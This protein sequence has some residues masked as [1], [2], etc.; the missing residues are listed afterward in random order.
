MVSSPMSQSSLTQLVDLWTASPL[1]FAN[2]N[3]HPQELRMLSYDLA[4]WTSFLIAATILNLAPGPDIAFILGHT[5][6]GGRASGLAAM[7]GIWS[8]A[9][10]HVAFAAAG[11]SAIVATSALA[12]AAIKWVG[13][14]YLLWLGVQ[15]LRSKGGS[16]ASDTKVPTMGLGPI[17]RQGILIDLLN[18]KVAIFFLAFLPQFVAPGAGPV[19]LQLLV[20]G[21][22]IIAIS[23][24]IEPPIVLL[25]DWLTRKL[26][27]SNRLALWLD[28]TVGAMLL[29]L[30]IKLATTQR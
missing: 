29:G 28:R 18:P 11:L 9:L 24:V 12:F 23:A 6:R 5:A 15:Y 21:L 3:V 2:P 13:V 19:W 16:F 10:C 4:H 22:L 30:G 8:G 7:F 26:R 27:T 14:V 1:M 20:H 25:G 17:F